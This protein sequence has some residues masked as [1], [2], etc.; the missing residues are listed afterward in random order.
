MQ[1]PGIFKMLIKNIFFGIKS[2]RL[3]FIEDFFFKKHILY[4]YYKSNYENIF[5]N[6][7]ND[8]LT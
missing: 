4:I 7:K 2:F 8:F 3:C 1:S 5:K 6:L